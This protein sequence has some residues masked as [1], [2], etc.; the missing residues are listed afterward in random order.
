MRRLL[1]PLVLATLAFPAAA[2]ASVSSTV[3]GGTLTVTGDASDDQI[4][5]RPGPAGTVLVGDQSFT[6]VSEVAIRSGA[7]ADE[8]RLDALPVAV[9]VDGEGGADTV[10]VRGTDQDE[11]LTLQAVGTHARLAPEFGG[12]IDLV[13]VETAQVL[14]G[15][16]ATSSTSATSR[17]PTSPG[18]TPISGASTARRTAC[19]WPGPTATTGSARRCSAKRSGCPA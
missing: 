15:D 12:F 9:R 6:A 7:G 18:S 19:S 2:H 5:V 11:E 8:I 4:N 1:L 3:S 14:A 16:G 13:G 17:P 10:R